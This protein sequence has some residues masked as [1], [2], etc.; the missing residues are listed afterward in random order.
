MR[1]GFPHVLKQI[2]SDIFEFQREVIN[3]YASFSHSSPRIQATEFS[4]VVDAEYA[5]G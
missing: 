4:K 3:E 2:M 5:R 1:R